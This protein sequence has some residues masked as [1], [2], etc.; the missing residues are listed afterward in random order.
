M[1][2]NNLGRFALRWRGGYQSD[3]SYKTL[4]LMY[5]DGSTFLCIEPCTNTP[6]PNATHWHLMSPS[7]SLHDR[8]LAEAARDA[9]Q[10]AAGQ[11]AG[12]ASAAGAAKT[13]AET[14]AG[15]AAGS[16]SAAEAAREAAVAAVGQV[17]T[18]QSL[19]NFFRPVGSIYQSVDPTSP[20]ILFGGVWAELPHN[21]YLK[22]ITTGDAGVLG[23]NETHDHDL[24]G[25]YAKIHFDNGATRYQLATGVSWESNRKLTV[26]G[27]AVSQESPT[28]GYGQSLGGRTDSAS[29]DP[30]NY[31]VHGWRRTA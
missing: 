30:L 26:S 13:D 18:I 27:Q 14:A 29:N 25:G 22:N 10:T 23:G 9:A 11:A 7:P 17:P 5:T 19:I 21:R 12:N 2:G 3:Y 8:T 16:A 24:S 6:P 1:A 15:Q 4:D 28:L 20:A 31:S